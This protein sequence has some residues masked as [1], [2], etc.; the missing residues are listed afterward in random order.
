MIR[1]PAELRQA[2]HD[3]LDRAYA[4]WLAAGNRPIVYPPGVS[5]DNLTP[6]QRVN[7]PV[8]TQAERE[9]RKAAEKAL[10]PRRPTK[11]EPKDPTPPKLRVKN[12][13][14]FAQAGTQKARILNLLR[15]GALRSDEIAS[16]LGM[17]VEIVRAN[18]HV[19]KDRCR[20]MTSG[21]RRAF[22]WAL[23]P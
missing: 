3:A 17:K 13:P 22:L 6:R 7:P 15:D 9:A 11:R 1:S 12:G 23:C 2:E 14:D 5:G 8:F 21:H 4:D 20:V 16:R 19:L 18:L 10:V